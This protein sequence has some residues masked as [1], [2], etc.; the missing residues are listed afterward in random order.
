MRVVVTGATGNA[1]TS[2]LH[3]LTQDPAV[4]E[5]VGLARRRPRLALPRTTLAAA[6]GVGGRSR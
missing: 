3:A 6:T 5:I 1:G 4:R 2:V